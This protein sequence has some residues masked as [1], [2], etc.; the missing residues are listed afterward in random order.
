MMAKENKKIKAAKKAAQREANAAEINIANEQKMV[1][2]STAETK[3]ATEKKAER[4][5]N[6]ANEQKMV[7][8]S[9]AE[10]KRT[11]VRAAKKAERAA[12]KAA[13][14]KVA[15]TTKPDLKAV[16]E[17]MNKNVAVRTVKQVTYRTRNAIKS[18]KFW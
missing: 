6:L 10:Q 9:T 11:A 8:E 2:E 18:L 7:K 12:N 14:I 13:S 1:E 17:E 4:A 15:E 5:A 16:T 3:R